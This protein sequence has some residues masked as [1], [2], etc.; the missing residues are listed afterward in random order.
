MSYV[1]A[2]DNGLV[3]EGCVYTY[4]KE[5][6]KKEEIKEVEPHS[7]YFLEYDRFEPVGYLFYKEEGKRRRTRIETLKSGSACAIS[8][9]TYKEVF[10]TMEQAVKRINE[11]LKD[12]T[13]NYISLID[14]E[15]SFL[16]FHEKEQH[17]I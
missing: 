12:S 17:I 15:D 14:W 1:Y 10:N 2:I 8:Y 13:V 3:Y 16:Y 7:P 11:L 5:E 6:P 4:P 9:E